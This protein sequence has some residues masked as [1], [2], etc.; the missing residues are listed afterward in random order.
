ME[1]IE[2]EHIHTKLHFMIGLHWLFFR[3][4][5]LRETCEWIGYLHG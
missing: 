3:K 1:A 2:I 4:A 5:E